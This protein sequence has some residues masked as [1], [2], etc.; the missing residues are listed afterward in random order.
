M[1]ETSCKAYIG[2]LQREEESAEMKPGNGNIL[3]DA[4]WSDLK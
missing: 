2:W 1:G 3:P 4:D